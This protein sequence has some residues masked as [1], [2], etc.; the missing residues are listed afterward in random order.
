MKTLK[1][2]GSA[3]FLLL[4]ALAS[5]GVACG[6]PRYAK[7]DVDQVVKPSGGEANAVRF[8][9]P[10][11]AVVKAHIIAFNDESKR[12]EGDVVSG[13]PTVIEINRV[14]SGPDDYALLGLRAGKTTLKLVAGGQVTR[15][16][17]AEVF[18]TDL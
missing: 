8:R 6:G 4:V 12:M 16:V 15:E 9:V 13:D 7:H 2:K 5:F 18:D 11:G 10:H 3:R 1:N 17:E 14:I